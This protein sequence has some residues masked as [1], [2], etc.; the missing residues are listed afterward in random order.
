MEIIEKVII[1][2][3][4]ERNQLYT[5]FVHAS[6]GD[7]KDIIDSKD[8]VKIKELEKTIKDEGRKYEKNKQ[9]K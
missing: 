6:Q 7:F 9:S 5:L 2:N 3:S 4:S 1:K 8:D